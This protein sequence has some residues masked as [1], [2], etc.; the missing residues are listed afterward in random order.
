MTKSI[1]PTL[2]QSV[3]AIEIQCGYRTLAQLQPGDGIQI[4]TKLV[5]DKDLWEKIHAF[6]K[7]LTIEL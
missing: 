3:K 6:E 4:V 1:T 7:S 5:E 2:R